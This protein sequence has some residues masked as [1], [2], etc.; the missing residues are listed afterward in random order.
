MLLIDTMYVHD[1][2]GRVLL[3][4]LIKNLELNNIPC[5]YLFDQRFKGEHPPIT[6][7]NDFIYLEASLWKRLQFYK[8]NK[9]RFSKIFCFGNLPPNIKTNAKV[10]TYYHSPLY[11]TSLKEFSY[12]ERFKQLLKRIILKKFTPNSD[13]WLVQTKLIK[14]KL[15]E[16]FLVEKEKINLMPFFPPFDESN[17]TGVREKNS[18]IFVSNATVHKNHLRLIKAFCSFFDTH[19]KGKLY[20]TVS[21][22]YKEIC[23]VIEKSKNQGY[24]IINV[25]FVTR[26]ELKKLYL[27]IEY[28]IFP[29]L[30][31]T[32]GLGLVEAIDNGCKVIGADL[33][34]TYAVCQ[35]SIVFNPY[36]EKSIEKAF[37]DASLKEL[38]SS[39]SIISNEINSLLKLLA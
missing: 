10:I 18:F 20:L 29:S 33:P 34:Y 4:Y 19:Q 28:L 24:P 6:S 32:F 30:A 7:S 11:F 37:L 13:L 27:S 25:G 12:M 14:E 38:A 5:Y 35:P 15:S 31:E 17:S 8:R 26:E 3:N 1:G 22:D 21:K 2:G 16:N 9:K 39:K 23:D 36:D